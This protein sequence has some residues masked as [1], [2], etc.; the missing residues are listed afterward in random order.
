[1]ELNKESVAGNNKSW[2]WL[3][4]NVNDFD[5]M[6]KFSDDEV[7]EDE[8]VF[9]LVKKQGAD[10]EILDEKPQHILEGYDCFSLYKHSD[11]SYEWRLCKIVGKAM[12]PEY[13]QM[14]MEAFVDLAKKS[15]ASVQDG[16][17]NEQDPKQ[18]GANRASVHDSDQ[19]YY[20]LEFQHLKDYG[21]E[22]GVKRRRE[23]V[24]FSARYARDQPSF[25]ESCHKFI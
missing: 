11:D 18:G 22:M 14:A 2:Q 21:R 3:W 7:F 23:D 25:E 20:F 12:K 10:E 8:V 24:I 4:K 17:G 15:R 9:K 5:R 13:K 1:M 16:D 6:E 19:Y